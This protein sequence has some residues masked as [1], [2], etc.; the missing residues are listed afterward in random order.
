MAGRK[1][2]LS[3]T[4][5]QLQAER[6]QRQAQKQQERED[7]ERRRPLG[8][9]NFMVAGVHYEGRPEVIREY[10]REGDRVFLAL[11][12]RNQFSRNAVEVRLGN[13][14]QIGFVPED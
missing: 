8:S 6:Q 12:A 7:R 4:K 10:A 9:V 3:L 11:D 1:P 2:R 14:M 13:G 5:A